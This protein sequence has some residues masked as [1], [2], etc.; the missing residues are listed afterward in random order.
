MVQVNLLVGKLTLINMRGG[1][2][3]S[4]PLQNREERIKII[5][6][7]VRLASWQGIAWK[8]EMQKKKEPT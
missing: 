4:Y 6:Q 8:L 7:N 2:G 1:C 5:Q 3:S